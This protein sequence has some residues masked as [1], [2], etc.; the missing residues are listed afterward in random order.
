MLC[1]YAL[2]HQL[3]MVLSQKPGLSTQF[4]LNRLAAQNDCKIT[5][6]VS[7]LFVCRLFHSFLSVHIYFYIHIH[8]YF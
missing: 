8:F 3:C 5:H 4:D 6:S 7:M 1:L 2:I